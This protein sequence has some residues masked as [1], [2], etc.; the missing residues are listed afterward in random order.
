MCRIYVPL[1]RLACHKCSAACIFYFCLVLHCF[2]HCNPYPMFKICIWVYLKKKKYDY[3]EM[4]FLLP[5]HPV[6]AQKSLISNTA[7]PQSSFNTPPVTHSQTPFNTLP[8]NHISNVH[9]HGREEQLKDRPPSSSSPWPQPP[10]TSGVSMGWLTSTW[11]LHT[12]CSLLHQTSCFCPLGLYVVFPV[13][14]CCVSSI[15]LPFLCVYNC[16]ITS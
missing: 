10:S 12:A 2:R 6:G 11:P 15:C 9:L 8:V 7:A 4:N 5:M 16:C 1:S 13:S 3:I 14:L